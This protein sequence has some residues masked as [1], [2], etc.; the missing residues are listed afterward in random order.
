MTSWVKA[1]KQLWICHSCRQLLPFSAAPLLLLLLAISPVQ[2]FTSVNR[3][4]VRPMSTSALYWFLARSNEINSPGR[5]G[6]FYLLPKRAVLCASWL[7][8]A[9][10][11]SK[12]G[13]HVRFFLVSN[14]RNRGLRCFP[15]VL[16]TFFWTPSVVKHAGKSLRVLVNT[17]A[18]T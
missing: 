15:L 17:I 11:I 9:E 7:T 14:C 5:V 6:R 12:S 8:H 2:I 10:K 1:S 3:L 18:T 13:H 16:T 4:K